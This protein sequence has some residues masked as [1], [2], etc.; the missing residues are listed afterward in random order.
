MKKKYHLESK[1]DSF[2]LHGYVQYAVEY[3]LQ[4]LSFW[5]FWRRQALVLNSLQNDE[6]LT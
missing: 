6:I 5:Q 3:L 1:S 2:Q 4:D